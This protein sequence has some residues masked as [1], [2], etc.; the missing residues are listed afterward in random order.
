MSDF[1]KALDQLRE[2]APSEQFSF[3][4][5][6]RFLRGSSADFSD[7]RIAVMPCGSLPDGEV[8]Q[9]ANGSHYVIRNFYGEGH[10]HG[11]VRIGRLS[12]EEL[13]TL[14]DLARCEHSVIERDRIVFL[15]TETTGVSGGA[16]MCPFL[17]GLGFF[18]D[19]EFHVVQYFIRDFDE[20]PS[21]LLALGK[22]LAEFDLIVTYNGQ[23]FDL[24]LV[25]NRFIL[26]RLDK[27]FSH[28]AHFDLLFT[29]RRLWRNG[30][31]SCKLTALEQKLVRFMRGP[32]IHG[33]MI[34]R[35]YFKYLQHRD[36]TPL[37]SVFSHNIY[38]ILSL[39]ALAIHCCDRVVT[40][41]AP[42]DDPLDVYSLGRVFDAVKERA[43]SVRCY[44]LALASP[45]PSLIRLRALE[46]LSILYRRTGAHEKSI[47]RCEQ[48]MAHPEF[49]LIGYEG[50]SIFYERRARDLA[51]ASKVLDE[52]LARVAGIKRLERRS[53]RLEAR[54]ERLL[55][56][57]E[58]SQRLI[59]VV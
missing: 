37:K 7:R 42:L 16:G 32:D 59:N 58:S 14:L 28:M 8:E 6:L 15:D 49:S 41:P 18:R 22:L 27:P 10:F 12:P 36:P 3:S 13:S 39:A 55:R 50:A 17:I 31:G 23:S 1:R 48:L 24:P 47:E 25:E 34:P 56:K 19:D 30:H 53:A 57:A 46:R 29:A 11:K 20:E 45:L 33:S 5:Q 40:E 21:M 9:T 52:A 35:A 2:K 4:D 44:E 38:D 26:A 51:A 43:K 54:R